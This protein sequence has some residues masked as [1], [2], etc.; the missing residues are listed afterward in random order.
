MATTGKPNGTLI[1]IYIGGVKV[2]H[3]TTNSHQVQMA[4]RDT[5]TKDSGGWKEGAGGQLSWSA[6][7]EGYFAEDAT[8]GY[9]DLY[10]AL[11]A[12]TTLTVMISSAV[13]GDVK[14]TGSALITSLERTS[15]LEETV[16]F[17][18][19]LEG[20]SSLVKATI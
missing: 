12:R 19:S 16:T 9:E 3:L 18:C 6:S 10:D 11:I 2:S 4:I 1:C 5:S 17:T 14:Y 20:I 8:Y 15:P 13:T 7:C